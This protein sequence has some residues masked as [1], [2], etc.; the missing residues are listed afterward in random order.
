MGIVGF[1]LAGGES[2][3]ASVDPVN[4]KPG[5]NGVEGVVIEGEVDV[6]ESGTGVI[7]FKMIG[8]G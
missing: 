1:C 8:I 2:K 6:R 5:D 4:W 7:G 3:L